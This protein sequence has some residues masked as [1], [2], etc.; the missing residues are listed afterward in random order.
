MIV[1]ASQDMSAIIQDFANADVRPER[2]SSINDSSCLWY[3]VAARRF[4]DSVDRISMP[5]PCG[6]G[7][8]MTPADSSS[9]FIPGI[10][11]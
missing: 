11:P 4:A 6:T 8:P 5:M 10:Q 3:D 9:R 2:P 7:A 1:V